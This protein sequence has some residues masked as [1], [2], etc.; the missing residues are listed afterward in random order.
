[1][2]KLA[3]LLCALFV[4]MGTYAQN[5]QDEK[6]PYIKTFVLNPRSLPDADLQ[7]VFRKT[8][9]WQNFLSENG[10][11]WVEFNEVNGQPRRASGKGI[12]TEGAT[13]E[14]RA[15]HFISNNLKD[16]Q[17]ETASL[18]LVNVLT[19]KYHYVTFKQQYAG[20]DILG[21]EVSVRMTKEDNK[22]IMF[23]LNTYNDIALSII[24]SISSVAAASFASADFTIPVNSTEVLPSLAILPIPFVNSGGYQYKLV[25]T[26]IV[27]TTGYDNIPGK[28]L[29]MVDANNGEVLYRVNEVHT[30]GAYL[31][32]ATADV[33][34]AITDNP[35]VSTETRGLPYIRVT[36]DGEH[37]F[38]D[39]NGILNLDFITEPTDA[40]INLQGLYAIVYQGATGS[41][42]ES[43]SVTLNPG[44]NVIAFDTESGA[45]ASEVSA[46]YHQNIV[47]DYLKS[48]F[49]DFTDLDFAQTIRTDRTDGSCNAFYDGSSIN[50]YTAGGGCPAT[51][52]FSDVVYHEYGHGINYDLYAALGDPG[53]MNN[54]AMQEGYADIWGFTITENPILGQGFS[55]SSSS[56]VRRYDVEPAVYPD[57]LV[58]E[59][60]ADGEIIAGAW[61]DLYENLDENM[62]AMI[63]IWKE[64][65]NATVDG[66]SGNEGAIYR[67][68]LLE[69]L[70]A[71]DDNADLADGTPNDV[72]IIEAFAEHGITLLANAIVVHD[73]PT[74]ALP[75]DE[76]VIIE[77]VLDVDFPAYLGEF[78]MYFRTS[79]DLDFTI[80]PLVE[81]GSGN[82]EANLGIL[83]AGTIVEYYFE[84]VDIYGG[85]AVLKPKEVSAADPN[86]PY[87][88]LVG[89]TLNKTEDFDN[90]FG[91][92]EIDPN[93]T[94]NNTTGT[95]TV[96]SPI[97]TIDGTYIVQTGD[98][99]TVG[100]S[101]LCAFT[102]N[103]SPGDGLGTNDVD[104]G[105]TTLRSPAFDLTDME[106]PVFTYYRWYA[107]DSPTSANPGN[108]VWRAFI[109]NNETDWVLIEETYT[110]DNSWR[111]N[112][113]RVN[114]YVSPSATVYL[115]FV[116]QDS[117]IPSADL[118][119]GSL[120]EAAI[121]DLQLWE[122]GEEEEPV[123]TNETSIFNINAELLI[124]NIYPNPT[125]DFVQ[126]EIL[127]YLGE[128]NLQLFNATGDLVLNSVQIAASQTKIV[129][130][131]NNLAEGI[132]TISV[133]AGEFLKQQ[134]LIIQK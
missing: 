8:A 54:G 7:G 13:I 133:K 42:L 25:Y 17:K 73:E 78:N 97:E 24:P 10:A 61:W 57:D 39:E 18:E 4:F 56:Y 89:F 104:G 2:K 129:L 112:A 119:G 101:N 88:A 131:L 19:S 122:M 109:S 124:G 93:G 116:A 83:P 120:V 65:L 53:G 45:T 113:V 64:T 70:L 90:T 41:S 123:D 6:D 60:H 49:P 105:K 52:L 99:F 5:A 9:A 106:D 34:S 55:G 15:I 28:Y 103:A 80:A 102:G 100:F 51:A 108:D 110:S 40:T 121:D 46:Y 132:Y 29:T 27:N 96:D 114:D 33:Q 79:S 37:Y 43:I 77:A 92:W 91:D 48:L 81:V 71:D 20:L 76:P 23:G 115:L 35:L 63:A 127:D 59:V 94:D 69:A 84:V 47:H 107:N 36:I 82:Y 22:V 86:L 31:M 95:W 21:S 68:V 16:Y 14:E 98:D 75:S 72:A 85:V 3:L 67:D 38:A 30:C 87:Y 117:I 32:S 62:P 134:N 128:V 130:P 58:G 125:S 50:F 11:W 12:A 74:V 44:D 66:F 26:V 118:E 111:K 126:I 1:M